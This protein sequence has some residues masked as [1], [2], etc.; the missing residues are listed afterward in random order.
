MLDP[1]KEEE[2][3]RARFGGSARADNLEEPPAEA[4][5]EIEPVQEPEPPPPEAPKSLLLLPIVIGVMAGYTLFDSEMIPAMGGLGG[6]ETVEVVRGSVERT[7]RVTGSI[8]A[9]RSA[10]IR[11]PRIRGRGGGGQLT[12]IELAATS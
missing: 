2:L 4:P 7:I 6:V 10:A 3:L 12:L 11:T 5:P 8:A 1:K 9:R